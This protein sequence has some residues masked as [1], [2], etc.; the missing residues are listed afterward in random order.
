MKVWQ[1]T[2]SL[3]MAAA[4]WA[5]QPQPPARRGG[6]GGRGAWDLETRLTNRLGLNATQ[7]N[8]LHTALEEERT[9]T[10]GM[11]QQRHTLQ[12]SLAGAIKSGNSDQIDSITQQM[13]T[14]DQQREAIHAKEMVKVYSALTADQK[15]KVGPN[16]E[17]LLGPGMRGPA[18]GMG[19]AGRT[20]K[21]AQQ[22]Q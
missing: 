4:I 15:T 3:F 18:M 14:L 20:P 22:N 2:L 12:Q 17:M 7:Q 11:M 10:K 21:P 8:T 19:R 16:L 6:P 5:Q 9:Q 1:V 13:S